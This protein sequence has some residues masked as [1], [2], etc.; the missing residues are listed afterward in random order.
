MTQVTQPP[1][2]LD[3]IGESVL[4]ELT[5]RVQDIDNSYRAVAEKMGQLYMLADENKVASLTSSLDKPM[6]NASDNEQMFS[7]ILE[8]LRVHANRRK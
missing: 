6:R 3:A 7:A 8:E 2:D 4:K 5:R 1:K